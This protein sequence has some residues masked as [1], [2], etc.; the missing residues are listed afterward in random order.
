MEHLNVELICNALGHPEQTLASSLSIS[1]T[2]VLRDVCR[3]VKTFSRPRASIGL[4]VPTICFAEHPTNTCAGHGNFLRP[5]WSS[6]CVEEHEQYVGYC[7]D[8]S[9]RLFLSQQK[10]GNFLHD[11]A[12]TRAS[13]SLAS[14][15]PRPLLT[16][17]GQY[18]NI[19]VGT[20]T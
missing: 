9:M 12:V 2:H 10:P 15:Y 14:W 5:I 18:K 4:G 17:T 11:V 13:L 16:G 20:L 6:W 19:F 3:C 1:E 8:S 7:S